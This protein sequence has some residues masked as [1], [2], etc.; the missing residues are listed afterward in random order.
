[1]MGAIRPTARW[2]A[3][4]VASLWS[5]T[6]T[7]SADDWNFALFNRPSAPAQIVPHMGVDADLP[8][9]ATVEE[10]EPKIG[11]LGFYPLSDYVRFYALIRCAEGSYKCPAG[12]SEIFGVFLRGNPADGR[13]VRIVT[14]ASQPIVNDGGCDVLNLWADATTHKV[15]QYACGGR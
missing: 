13:R 7:A 11:G 14:A 12:G 3:V 1:M 10:I 5:M 2:L 6:T 9:L 8:A 15:I 4:L